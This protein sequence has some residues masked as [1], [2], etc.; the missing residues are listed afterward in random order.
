MCPRTSSDLER[1]STGESLSAL[2]SVVTADSSANWANH[3]ATADSCAN[4]ANHPD[5]L[6][7]AYELEHVV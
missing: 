2:G 1:R 4:W 7:E 3:R 6:S 5:K